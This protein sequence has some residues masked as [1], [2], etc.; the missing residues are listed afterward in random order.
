MNRGMNKQNVV[1]TRNEILF[2]LKKELNSATTWMNL[3]DIMLIEPV[4]K[5]Q[6]LFDS[7]YMRYL[8][9]VVKFIEAE[10]RMVVSRVCVRK[11]WRTV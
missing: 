5:R 2:S 8:P 7:T 6:I 10:S 9:R 4:R 11:E 1:Y 3:E